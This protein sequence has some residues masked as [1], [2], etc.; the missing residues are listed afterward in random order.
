ME[1][2]GEKRARRRLEESSE[3]EKGVGW[4]DLRSILAFAR[5]YCQN[6]GESI[7]ACLLPRS[8]ALGG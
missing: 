4:A 7:M 6:C 1:L 2:V 5:F 8:G 3:K